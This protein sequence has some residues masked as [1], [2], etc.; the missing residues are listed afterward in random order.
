[1]AAQNEPAKGRTAAAASATIVAVAL[2]AIFAYYLLH[3]FNLVPKAY[4]L[5]VEAGLVALFGVLAVIIVGR[6]VRLE[7][8]R[9][10]GP[11][12][13]YQVVDIYRLVAYIV[14]AFVVLA[15]LGVSGTAL[16]AGGTFAGLVIGLAAQTA[17]GN[18]FAG[19]LLLAT[20]PFSEGDRI[21]IST[22]Q[23]GFLGPAYPPKFYSDDLLILGFTGT[24]RTIGLAYSTVLR[25]DGTTVKLPNSIV[26]N[27][28]AISHEVGERWVRTKYEV[29]P[30]IDPVRL[31]STVKERISQSSWV[32]RPNSVRV[33]IGAATMASYVVVVDAFC[34]G[35]MEE[36]VRSDFLQELMGI[37]DRLKAEAPPG[38]PATSVSDPTKK[39]PNPVADR[40]PTP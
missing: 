3:V 21:T 37:V 30:Q 2:A 34:R 31:I 22:W 33:T 27:A 28:A 16:L 4:N 38:P 36:P 11:E 18:L 13:A 20:R 35:S 32:V 25:D 24:I 23:F 9:R 40:S 26:I 7:S 1:M 39:G 5:Y 17:L 10:L 29:P 6:I 19:I 14:L 8:A 12:R 15:V